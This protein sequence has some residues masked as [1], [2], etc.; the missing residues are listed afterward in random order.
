MHWLDFMD[1]RWRDWKCLPQT[2][3]RGT[4]EP[5]RSEVRR[6]LNNSAVAVDGTRVKPFDDVAFPMQS[7]VLFPKG[8]RITLL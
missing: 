1:K 5:T 4:G 2:R 7:V 6:W 3:E 8:N